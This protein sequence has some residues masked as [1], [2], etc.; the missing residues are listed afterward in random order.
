M[1]FSIRVPRRH[2]HGALLILGPVATRLARRRR[3]A[4]RPS[5][6]WMTLVMRPA[7][8]LPYVDETDDP[9]VHALE[10]AS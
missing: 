5:D 6:A 1:E 8:A 9:A 2:R 3:D 10:S 7:T 4:N